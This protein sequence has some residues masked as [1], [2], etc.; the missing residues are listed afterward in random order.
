M[1]NSLKRGTAE[2][3][4]LRGDSGKARALLDWSPSIDFTQLVGVL[5]DA[6]LERLQAIPTEPLR[7]EQ[8]TPG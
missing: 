8:T 6:E 7:L 4:D 2:L 1:D 5:V 3:H